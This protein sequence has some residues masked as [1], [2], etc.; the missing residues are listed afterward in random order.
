MCDK[1]RDIKSGRRIQDPHKFMYSILH[2]LV[3][4]SSKYLRKA[5]EV[6]EKDVKL[7]Q[8]AQR[9]TPQKSAKEP[10]E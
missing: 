9:E 1:T 4:G 5:V 7:K 10:E 6:Q 2:N 3:P 8:L